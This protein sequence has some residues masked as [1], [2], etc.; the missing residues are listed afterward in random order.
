MKLFALL[1]VLWLATAQSWAGNVMTPEDVLK[2]KTCMAATVSPNGQWIAY[3][4]NVPRLAN[5]EAGGAYSELHVLT[6]ATG[7]TRPFITGK[8]TIRSPQW[9]PDSAQIAFLTTRGQNTLSQVWTIPVGGG[10]AA[11][12]TTSD[13]DVLAFRWHP[14]GDKLGYIAITPSSKKEKELQKR[15]Y[16]FVTY[17]ENLKHRNL[18][19]IATNLAQADRKAE[20]LTDGITVWEFVFSPD[21]KMAAATCSP[22]NLVDHQ[23]MFQN[24]YVLD[25]TTRQLSQLTHHAGKLG[26]FEYSPDSKRLVYGAALERKDHAVSQVFC[27][28]AQGGEPVN[29]TPAGL[30]AHV[31]WVGW[32]DAATI[33]YLASEGVYNSLT[34]MSLNDKRP[35]PLLHSKTCGVIFNAPDTTLDGR[36]YVMTGHSPELP[37]EVY[38]WS[39]GQELQRL[40]TVNPWLLQESLGRQEVI[41]YVTRDGVSEEGIL[42]YP[43]DY[44][45]G[46]KYPLIVT[47]HGGPESHYS[48]GWLT[49]YFH[50]AQVLAAKG[51]LVFHPNYR[52]ST[53]YGT[54]FALAGYGDPAGKEFDDIADGIEHLVKIG[55]A[56]PER[57]GL[58]GGSYGGYAAAWFATFYTKYVKAVTM[59][60]GVSNLISKRNTTDIPYEELYVHSGRG[61]EEMWELSLKRSPIYWASQSKTAVLILGGLSDPRV[62]PG[63]SLELYRRLNMNN[64]PAVRLVQYPGEGHGNARQPG[65][66]DVLYRHLQWYDWYVR[67]RKPLDGAMPPL[68]ISN[69]YGLKFE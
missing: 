17:E 41:R 61:L 53:G 49:G 13:T 63:Q 10:E 24:L 25:L 32:Q 57:I 45:A 58:G 11:Q 68:D 9:S 6:V 50:P 51:Y 23:Y 4:V 3:T 42:V 14:T 36:L 34:A 15:G 52:A 2:I 7:E 56:D 69:C 28:D 40:T 31:A 37:T 35:R 8:V 26:N 33:I 55:L 60:V 19:L 38:R 16:G 18:Y 29:L 54:A 12:I 66:I 44:A 59:F 27:L 21:G 64:H 20:Q 62:H 1:F 48:Q 43:V 46:Q 22:K 67:D 30:E 65:R 39:P 47:V 5:D